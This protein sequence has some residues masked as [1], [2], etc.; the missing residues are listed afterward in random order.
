M[1]VPWR[2]CTCTH[3]YIY[4]N[5]V[6]MNTS[7]THNKKYNKIICWI[8]S[9]WCQ[10]LPMN[11]VCKW[12]LHVLSTLL[13]VLWRGI[14]PSEGESWSWNLK[15]QR[16]DK[17]QERWVRNQYRCHLDPCDPFILFSLSVTSFLQSFHSH[18]DQATMGNTIPAIRDLLWLLCL[19]PTDHSLGPWFL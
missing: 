5:D 9:H 15:N 3:S 14:L 18:E 17:A 7:Y 1:H 4:M 11:V 10:Q 16:L 8:M 13:M 19:G 12:S 6:Y 2:A